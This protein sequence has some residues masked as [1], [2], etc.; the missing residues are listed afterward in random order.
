MPFLVHL[1][2]LRERRGRQ[3]GYQR[4]GN[5]QSKEEH[6][7]DITSEADDRKLLLTVGKQEG[8]TLIDRSC[9]MVLGL[10]EVSDPWLQQL[11]SLY[12]S[13]LS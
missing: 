2:M 8:V 13:S 6:C 9:T 1:M 11:R 12:V 4:T 7:A 10:F 5:E 3:P